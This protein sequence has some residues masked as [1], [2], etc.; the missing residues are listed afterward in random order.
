M[1]DL[2]FKISY[3]K[4]G[5]VLRAELWAAENIKILS[6]NQALVETLVNP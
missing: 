1:Q 5:A 4:Q 3:E 6:R 2:R